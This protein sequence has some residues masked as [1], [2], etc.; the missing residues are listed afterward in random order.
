MKLVKILQ[1]IGLDEKEAKIYLALLALKEA[2]IKQ[3]AEHAEIPRTSAYSYIQNMLD[4]GIV[5]FYQKKRRTLY[6][7]RSPEKLLDIY[8]NSLQLYRESIPRFERLAGSAKLDSDIRFFSGREGIR[9][10]FNEIIEEKKPFLAIT[11]VDDMNIIA[12]EYFEDFIN[13]RIKNR[14]SVKLLTN[15]TAEALEMKKDDSET[16]RETRFVPKQYN[17]RSANYIFGDKIAIL[18]LKQEPV[19]GMLIKDAPLTETNRMYFELMWS[20]AKK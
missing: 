1:Q 6:I 15:L 16:F 7:P 20:I 19:K 14:L 13:L 2:N 18:S 4:K 11:S 12:N 5:D 9:L 10:I 8:Q 17:F 3:I